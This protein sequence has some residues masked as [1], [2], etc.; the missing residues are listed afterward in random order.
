MIISFKVAAG[1]LASGTEDE[2]SR[3]Q[4]L[5]KLLTWQSLFD[6]ASA[7]YEAAQHSLQQA[8]ALLNSPILRAKDTLELKWFLA[9][10]LFYLGRIDLVEE[11][12]AEQP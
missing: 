4:L 5:L 2:A 1:S 11:D 3:S 8:Q 6:L 10:A 12:R 9:S 7:N